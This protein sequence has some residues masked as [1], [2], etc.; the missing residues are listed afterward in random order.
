MKQNYYVL[1]RKNIKS[2]WIDKSPYIEGVSWWSGKSIK[3]KNLNQL[4]FKLKPYKKFSADHAQYLPVILYTNPPLFRDDF[5]E[6]LFSFGV[7]NIETYEVSILDPDDNSIIK[8]YK[9]VNILEMISA[10]DMKLSLATIHDNVPL[11]DVDFDVLI[12]DEKK[13]KNSMLFRL[14]ESVS[15]IMIHKKL[16]D[17]LIEK[18]FGDDL[19]FYDPRDVAT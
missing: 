11:I 7:K 10:A 15:T 4:K 13:T 5:V 17:Y 16:R 6:A 14:A 18:G 8:N 1:S 19:E 12:I 2:R 9:A 3:E